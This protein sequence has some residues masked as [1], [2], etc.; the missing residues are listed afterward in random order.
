ME[1]RGLIIK[2]AVL[3]ELQ[4]SPNILKEKIKTNERAG[5][6]KKQIQQYVT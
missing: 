5:P 6:F 2:L 1:Q 3:E 4:P